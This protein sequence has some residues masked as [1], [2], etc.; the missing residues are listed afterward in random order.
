MYVVGIK[1]YK[2][3]CGGELRSREVL[4]QAELELIFMIIYHGNQFT[5]GRTHFTLEVYH[6][7]SLTIESL[8]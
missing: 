3:L 8:N 2:Y 1:V 6:M 4:M 5:F 7:I